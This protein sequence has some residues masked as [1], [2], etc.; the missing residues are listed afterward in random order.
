MIRRAIL[1]AA[2]LAALLSGCKGQARVAARPPDYRG[3]ILVPPLPEPDFTL[4]ATDGRPYHFKQE[5][6]AGVALLFFGYTHCPDVC[7]VHMSNLAAVLGRLPTDVSGRVKVVFVTVDP[8]RDTPRKL[9][10][11]L[12]N[13]DANFVGLRGSTDSV[14]QVLHL[15]HLPPAIFER[16]PDGTYAVG[17]GAPVIAMVGDSAR[18]YYPFG[19]RQEDWLHDLPI[20]AAAIPPRRGAD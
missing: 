20:L 17:H 13:F 9:R 3:D 12:D 2:A 18:V 7:P 16:L 10:A 19:I 11:W 8:K 1:S 15:F 5:T 14:N 4:T 6:G